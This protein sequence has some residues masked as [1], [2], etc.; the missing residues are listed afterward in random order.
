LRLA[1]ID[2]GTNAAKLLISESVPGGILKP[3][4]E[5]RCVT[6]LG[7]GVDAHGV[8]TEGA[9]ERLIKA[10]KTFQI[11]AAQYNA[12]R[13][14]V[15]GTSASRDTGKRI[16]DIVK[17]RTGL[18]YEIISGDQEADISFEGAIGGLPHI[19]GQVISCDIGGGS[20][21]LVEGTSDG[22][23]MKRLSLDIGSVR[24]SER[25]FSSQPP[26]SDELEIAR[27]FIQH[28]V[29]SSSF[30]GNSTNLLAG[31]SDTHRLLLKLQ[32]KLVAG[33]ISTDF[34]R[35]NSNWKHLREMG[36]H[37]EKLSYDQVRC[38]VECLMQLT[39]DDV[40]FLE[41]NELQGRADVFPAALLI[42]LEVMD[43]LG[44]VPVIVSHW[45]LAH[46]VALRVFRAG[47][48]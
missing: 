9:I 7:E 2:V 17:G 3:L 20:T 42:C 48:I 37:H 43:G 5:E 6:R 24:I 40:L 29:A 32:N 8:L 46:G 23:I 22:Q 41:P 4:R 31:A 30:S 34:D 10:L 15:V 12:E 39:F 35:F 28:S 14:V 26:D 45:G 11:I 25:Y 47:R 13:C 1:T 18:D 16:V 33:E 36:A 38:W 19:K 21:E 44:K 27:D